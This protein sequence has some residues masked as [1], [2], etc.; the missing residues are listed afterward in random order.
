LAVVRH[1]ETPILVVPAARYGMARWQ[2]REILVRLEV[3]EWWCALCCGI[4]DGVID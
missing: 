1:A 3:A 4:R 2:E